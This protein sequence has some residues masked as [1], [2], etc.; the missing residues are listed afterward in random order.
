MQDSIYRMTL[1]SHFIS[2]F[3]TKTSQFRLYGIICIFNTPVDYRF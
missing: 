1:K 2:E 3:R